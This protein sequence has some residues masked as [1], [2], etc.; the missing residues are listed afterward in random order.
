M[1]AEEINLAVEKAIRE[2]MN[3]ITRVITYGALGGFIILLVI[4]LAISV[5]Y[6]KD[7]GADGIEGQEW[8]SLFKDGFLVLSGVV[9]TL[10]GYYFGNRGTD[11][12]LQQVER[13][14]EESISL[15]E[16]AERAAPSIEE[17]D[18]EGF[19]AIDELVS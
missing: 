13:V 7:N 9:T 6:Y 11:L 16:A 18:T 14:R 10:I 5:Y 4:L 2:R 1:A 19:T 3:N 8:L 17:E 12:A 15:A